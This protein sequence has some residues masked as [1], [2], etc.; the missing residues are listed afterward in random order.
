MAF[1]AIFKA[2]RHYWF[3]RRKRILNVSRDP[4]FL[5][6]LMN[7]LKT[8]STA[9]SHQREALPTRSL[10]NGLRRY[11]SSIC[12]LMT[13]Y[14][15]SASYIFFKA[16]ILKAFYLQIAAGWKCVDIQMKGAM[17]FH[18]EFC[19]SKQA[20]LSFFWLWVCLQHDGSLAY[21]ATCK[22]SEVSVG[23]WKREKV[24]S[25]EYLMQM[26]RCVVLTFFHLPQRALCLH[27]DQMELRLPF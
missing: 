20:V 27:V 5:S 19:V 21:G 25:S 4:G 14:S 13:Q 9:F 23:I 8:V 22:I 18:K 16:R 17:H 7:T 11:A 10:L 1:L 15:E 2:M 26:D 12:S 6:P 24:F 3:L